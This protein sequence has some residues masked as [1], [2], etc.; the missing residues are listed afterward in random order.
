MIRIMSISLSGMNDAG[1]RI[2]VISHNIANA[3]T[4]G[5]RAQQVR[6][7]DVVHDGHGAGV[8]TLTVTHSPAQG[9]FI[10]SGEWSNVSINGSGYFAVQ[11]S[12]GRIYYT[13]NGSFRLNSQGYLVN[14]Q[15]YRVL[16]ASGNPIPALNPAEYTSFQI[17]ERGRIYGVTADGIVRDLG[18][19]YQIGV[20]KFNNEAGLISEGGTLYSPSDKSGPPDIGQAGSDGRGVL[21]SGLI[22][23]S[24]VSI[25]EEMVNMIV[26]KATYKANAQVISTADEMNKTLLDVKT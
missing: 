11:D 3:Q 2:G 7:A 18:Q 8:M 26:A 23:A 25:E 9:P 15:G 4:S 1:R 12:Q 10:E 19:D 20:A 17:D 21:L 14:E 13:R 24:N 5:F 6:S 16:N 22:E